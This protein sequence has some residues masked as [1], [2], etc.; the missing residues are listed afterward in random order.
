M[1][2]APFSLNVALSSVHQPKTPAYASKQSSKK[3]SGI[4]ISSKQILHINNIRIG[5]IEI[6]TEILPKRFVH[7]GYWEVLDEEVGV[8]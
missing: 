3:S 2:D 8:V 1:A 6:C 7:E 4:Y 5:L